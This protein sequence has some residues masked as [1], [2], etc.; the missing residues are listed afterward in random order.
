[1]CSCS[2]QHI[3]GSA[4]LSRSSCLYFPAMSTR[5]IALVTIQTTL[6][7]FGTSGKVD[8][9]STLPTILRL[10]IHWLL[11]EGPGRRLWC[12]ILWCRIHEG[13]APDMQK[14]SFPFQDHPWTSGRLAKQICRP[15]CGLFIEVSTSRLKKMELSSAACKPNHSC[16]NPGLYV[17]REKGSLMFM[18]NPFL[19]LIAAVYSLLSRHP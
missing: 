16:G 3:S 2:R 12:R 1:M 5:H 7:S 13:G 15:A 9:I 18:W 19:I 11:Y 8:Q 10:A 14:V 17:A 6:I 4:Y